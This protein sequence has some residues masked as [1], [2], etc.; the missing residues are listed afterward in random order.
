MYMGKILNVCNFRINKFAA[1]NCSNRP[2]E[3]T[4]GILLVCRYLNFDNV[5]IVSTA[6]SITA[7]M[8]LSLLLI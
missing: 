1:I 2:N 3:L 7:T 6:F 5:Y 8:A 4:E